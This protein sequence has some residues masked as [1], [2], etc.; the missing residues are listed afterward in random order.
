[1]SP[2]QISGGD[3]GYEAVERLIVSKKRAISVADTTRTWKDDNNGN[4]ISH[5]TKTTIGI[6]YYHLSAQ[7]KFT[8]KRI[9]LSNYNR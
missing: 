9:Q 2:Y 7:G 3:Q 8:H 6:T 5:S 1:M 4:T